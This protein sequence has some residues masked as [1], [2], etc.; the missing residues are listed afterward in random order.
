[1]A[2]KLRRVIIAARFRGPCPEQA[3]PQETR[4][5]LAA[6][7]APARDQQKL[8]NT[9]GDRGLAEA[10]TDGDRPRRRRRPRVTVRCSTTGA[11]AVSHGSTRSSPSVAIRST[12]AAAAISRRRSQRRKVVGTGAIDAAHGGRFGVTGGEVRVVRHVGSDAGCNAG[13]SSDDPREARSPAR[14]APRAT[15]G[16]TVPGPLPKT[17]GSAAVGRR[18]ERGV[19]CG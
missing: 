12:T 6:W 18:D 5:V 11:G 15:G 19:T 13:W 16:W 3:T 14:S 10:R 9:R 1:M 7:A 17:G 4:A 8:R 2:V